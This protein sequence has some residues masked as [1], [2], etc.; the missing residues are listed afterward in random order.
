MKV[1][2]NAFEHPLERLNLSQTRDRLDCWKASV[3]EGKLIRYSW[4][5]GR[6]LNR[7]GYFL[8]LYHRMASSAW[9]DVSQLNSQGILPAIVIVHG[10]NTYYSKFLLPWFVRARVIIRIYNIHVMK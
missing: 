4:L 3:N 10:K 2:A 8:L 5:Q 9:W 7:L 1:V 6:G